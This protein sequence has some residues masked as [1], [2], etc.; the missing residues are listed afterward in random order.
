[1]CDALKWSSYGIKLHLTSIYSI[2]ARNQSK[3]FL[4]MLQWPLKTSRSIPVQDTHA[5]HPLS[6]NLTLAPGNE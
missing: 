6:W 5:R 3:H 2:L 4:T 1:M